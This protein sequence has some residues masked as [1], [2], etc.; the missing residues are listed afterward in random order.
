MLIEEASGL[1]HLE[2]L[3]NHAS[4][5]IYE[6]S[7]ILVDKYFQGEVCLFIISVD[8]YVAYLKCVLNLFRM[9]LLD[10]IMK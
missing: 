2:A 7:Y 10:L 1:D 9:M 6:M 3:Q 5:K 8:M 4:H